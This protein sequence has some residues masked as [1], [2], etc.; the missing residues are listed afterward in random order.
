MENTN[1]ILHHPRFRKRL[2]QLRDYEKNR[3][4]CRHDLTHFLDVARIATILCQE[5]GLTLS[6]DFIY[7]TALLHDLGRLEQYCDG[8]DHAVASAQIAEFFLQLTN[9]SVVEKNLI[10]QAILEHRS[11]GGTGFSNVFYRADK[12]SR[13]CFACPVVDSCNWQEEKKNKDLI[14]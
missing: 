5:E 4:Y 9:F 8:T 10:Q 11:K 3:I 13:S 12:Y 6:R 2:E 14:Y 1:R 7:T